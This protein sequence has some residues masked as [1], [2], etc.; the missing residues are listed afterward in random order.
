MMKKLLL[1]GALVC[2]AVGMTAC[3]GGNN[4]AKEVHVGYFNNVTHA[5]A[6]L[7]KAEGKLEE[8]FGD[9]VQ[10]KWTAFNAGP[11]EVEAL[12][13]GDIDIG[14]IGP[15]P[16]VSANAKSNGDVVILSSATK[17]GAVLIT[18]KD[19]GIK[20]VADLS[21]K[22]VAIPQIGNTQHL[23]LL[24]LLADNGLKPTTDGGDVTVSAVAN[25]DVANTMERGDIDAAL[26]PEPWGA[27]LLEQ[28]A[29]LMLDYDEIYM[30]G[31][32]DVAV[33][34]V[35][36]EFMEEN[37]ELVEKFLAEH[38]AATL[39]IADDKDAS[40]KTINEEIDSATGK[41]LSESIIKEAFERIG[42]DS[43]LNRES[44]M[45]FAKISQEQKFIDAVPEESNLFAK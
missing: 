44:V 24:Q 43:E 19:S 15:V 22:T 7:M 27:T 13:A 4:E 33:V 6:L 11:A 28:G 26:V 30:D 31:K 34:V 45:G 16:A 20:S 29:E 40:L 3:G 42:V 17:G 37:P 18:G 21:G 5:Q 36:K 25:A 38:E 32:Y 8:S 14:Y 1:M 39:K 2:T 41:S 23:C 35:R 9:D 12:F 10:V